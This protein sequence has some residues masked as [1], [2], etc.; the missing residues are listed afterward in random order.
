MKDNLLAAGK[1]E[2]NVAIANGEYHGRVPAITV[3]PGGWWLEQES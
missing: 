3:V 1:E 2:R